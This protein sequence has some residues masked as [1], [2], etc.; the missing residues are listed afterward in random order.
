MNYRIFSF[1]LFTFSFFLFLDVKELSLCNNLKYLNPYIFATG[2]FEALMFQ[3]KIIQCKR[4]NSLKKLRSTTLGTKI[5]ELENQGLWQR[6]NSFT[7][8]ENNFL[9]RVGFGLA[10]IYGSK[11]TTNISIVLF[12]RI[13]K[14]C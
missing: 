7:T 11:V 12:G 8:K 4:I 1:G 5:L 6:L 2:W 10:Y 3:N 13:K 9:E 14:K